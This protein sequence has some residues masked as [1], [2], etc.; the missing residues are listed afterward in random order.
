MEE[1][2]PSHWEQKTQAKSSWAVRL[3][4]PARLLDNPW[5]HQLPVCP[6]AVRG[7]RGRHRRGAGGSPP[8]LAGPAHP[9][10]LGACP[11]V[12]AQSW[13]RSCAAQQTAGALPRPCP[14]GAPRPQ[15]T[16]AHLTCH[17]CLRCGPLPRAPRRGTT[18]GGVWGCS[19]EGSVLSADAG[20]Q[21]PSPEA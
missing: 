9:P 17:L 20:E 1:P 3:A 6:G 5:L 15:L 14:W 21:V 16:L 4:G 12:P 19:Q 11:G 7:G 10:H 2:A 18:S 13:N 8:R